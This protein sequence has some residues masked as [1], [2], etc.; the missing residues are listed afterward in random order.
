M[1]QPRLNDL[2]KGKI[3]KFSLNALLNIAEPLGLRVHITLDA[4]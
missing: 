1:T 4:A 3:S 2:L